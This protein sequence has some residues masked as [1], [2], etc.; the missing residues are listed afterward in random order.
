MIARRAVLFK[1]QHVT[2]SV[3]Y[4]QP[5]GFFFLIVRPSTF[6][7]SDETDSLRVEFPETQ[8][9]RVR[10]KGSVEMGKGLLA[11]N[12]TEKSGGCNTGRNCHPPGLCV[13]WVFSCW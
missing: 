3:L 9:H 6:F 8:K 12:R 2:Q 5:Q 7:F 13:K 11:L 10:A 1:T 4:V